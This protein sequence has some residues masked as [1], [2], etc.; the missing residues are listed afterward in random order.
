MFATLNAY[1]LSRCPILIMKS[2]LNLNLMTTFI[3]LVQTILG[4]FIIFECIW[5]D[6]ECLQG[7]KRWNVREY[8]IV[9]SDRLDKGSEIRPSNT[10]YVRPVFLRIQVAIGQNEQALVRLWS[11]LAPHNHIEKVFCIELLSFSIDAY[12]SFD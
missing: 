9:T 7:A 5:A 11:E 12:S 4:S 2:C 1:I 3:L 6:D 10:E 8:S